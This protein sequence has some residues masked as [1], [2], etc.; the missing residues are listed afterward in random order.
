MVTDGNQSHDQGLSKQ[1]SEAISIRWIIKSGILVP[2]PTEPLFHYTSLASFQEILRSRMLWA[3]HFRYLNDVTE[4]TYAVKVIADRIE[5][6]ITDAGSMNYLAKAVRSQ[7][8]S[9]LLRGPYV[10]SFSEN[11][12]SLSQWR[13][14]SWR[15]SGVCIGFNGGHLL[16]Q[17]SV[18]REEISGN[19][20]AYGYLAKC[21][22]KPS[23]QNARIDTLI[24]F[25]LESIKGK[26]NDDPSVVAHL[27]TFMSMVPIIAPVFKDQAFEEE[28]EWRVIVHSI[29]PIF[30]NAKFRFG[31]SMLI[32][33]LEMPLESEPG[34]MSG[35]IK[36]IVIGP[37]PHKDLS[38]DSVRRLVEM[39]FGFPPEIVSNSEVPYRHW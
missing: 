27:G 10:I 9:D 29:A 34:V 15:T 36:T 38:L 5:A 14:Y 25:L 2:P 13:G 18:M 37:T 21:V 20:S 30:K 26:E 39:Q 22:Y 19:E 7:L 24:D 3:S 31:D 11:G 1:D 8:P 12:D 16:G 28:E 6:R 23:E 32:P 4:F 17:L 35:A 33:Y